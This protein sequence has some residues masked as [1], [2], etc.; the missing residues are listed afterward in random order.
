MARD[1]KINKEEMFKAYMEAAAAMDNN[2]DGVIKNSKAMKENTEEINK[3]VKARE[4]KTETVKK[5]KISMNDILSVIKEQNQGFDK[6][7]QY[8]EK[9]IKA[10]EEANK[11]V[12]EE[13]KIAKETTKQKMADYKALEKQLKNIQK[14][15]EKTVTVPRDSTEEQKGGVL[16]S[17]YFDEKGLVKNLD[18][19]K[20]VVDEI[21]GETI[22]TF[23]NNMIEVLK[24]VDNEVVSSTVDFKLLAEEIDKTDELVNKASGY[25]LDTKEGQKEFADLQ[26]EIVNTKNLITEMVDEFVALA[27]SDKFDETAIE[28]SLRNI[29][30]T[31][32]ELHDLNSE[33]IRIME[34]LDDVPISLDDIASELEKVGLEWKDFK[35]D[36]ASTD[37]FGNEVK[38]YK[39][40]YGNIL[41]TTKKIKEVTKDGVTSQIEQYTY[42]LSSNYKELY[43]ESDK[44]LKKINDL[45]RGISRMRESADTKKIRI[46]KQEIDEIDKSLERLKTQIT[47][48]NKENNSEKVAQLTKEYSKQKNELLKLADSYKE[49]NAQIRNQGGWMLNLKDSFVKAFRSFTTYMSVTNVFYQS[50]AAI[51][52]MINEVKELD[53]VLTEF[54]KVSD[55]AGSS[56]D[57]YV[58]KAGELGTEVAK[59]TSEMID[60]ATEFKKSGFGD[61]ESLELGKVA[62]MY[63]NIADE[64]LSAASAASFIIAQMKAFKIE[65][66]DAIHIVDALNEVSNN[67]AVSSAQLA[68]AIGKVS[69]TMEAGNTSY[70]QTLGLLTAVTEV[71]RNADKAANALKTIGQRIRGVGEDGEDASEYVASLQKEFDKLGISL[72]IV[73]NSAGEMESTYNILK[74]MAEKWEDLTETQR[75]SLGE[76]AAGKNRITELNALMSNWQTAVDATTTALNSNGSAVRENAKVLDSIEGHLQSLRSEW[77]KLAT[78]F[79]SSGLLKT[80]I[81]LGTAILRLAQSGIGKFVIRTSAMTAAAVALKRIIQL[82]TKEF[83]KSGIEGTTLYRVFIL[84]TQGTK[85]LQRNLAAT[86]QGYSQMTAAEKRARLESEK[87]R[88]AS[89]KINLGLTLLSTAISLVISLWQRHNEKIE[90]A[91]TKLVET[92]ETIYSNK[93]NIDGY[94][95]SIKEYKKT[96]D[97]ATSTTKDKE[98]AT[99]ALEDIENKLYETYGL[100]A[101]NIDLVNGS[102]ED[103]LD[104]VK[105]LNAA[106]ADKYF[107]SGTKS[108]TKARKEVANIAG[109]NGSFISTLPTS[110]IQKRNINQAKVVQGFLEENPNYNVDIDTLSGRP[111]VISRMD[112][113]ETLEYY[114]KLSEYLQR[115]KVALTQETLSEK[116]YQRI[117]ENVGQEIDDITNKYGKY[118]D[119]LN[120]AKSMI[121]ETTEGQKAFYDFVEVSKDSLTDEEIDSL[122]EKY[123]SLATKIDL[124]GLSYDEIREKFEQ[125]EEAEKKQNETLEETL[126]KFDEVTEKVKGASDIYNT[127]NSIMNEY[128]ENGYITAESL[129]TVLDNWET[130]GQYLDIVNGK[131]VLNTNKLKENYNAQLD[132]A[133]A[134]AY[135]NA[136]KALQNLENG[137]VAASESA[138]KKSVDASRQAYEDYTNE[139]L[140]NSA[141]KNVSDAD[142]KAVQTN[143]NKQLALIKK[144][145]KSLGKSSGGSS[146]SGSSGTAEWEKAL[147]N[148]NNQYKNSEITIE[149]YIIKL[150]ALAKK[151]KKNKTAVAE[152]SKAIKD[153]RLEKLEDDYKRGL[154]GVEEYIKGLKELQKEYK[155]STKEWNNFADKIKSALETLLKDRE[156]DY[157]SAQS[158]AVDLLEEEI[159]RLNKLKDETEKYYDDLIAAKKEANEETERELE[160]ARLQE[161]LE[162]AKNN[163]TKRVFVEG[164]GWQ[165]MRDEEAVSEAQKALDEFNREQETDALEKE[166]EAALK[167]MDEK[168]EAAEQY[169][170]SWLDITKAYEDEQN[171]LI[172]AEIMGA[173]AE[174]RILNQRLDV[175]E[176]F[177]T[178]YINILKDLDLMDNITAD[179]ISQNGITL[180]SG[181]S[182]AEGGVVD[183]TGYAKVHG[184]ANKPEIML[185]N[186]QA[187]SLYSMLKTPNF[188][189]TKLAGGGGTQIYN[190]DNLV[191]PN[192][193]NARQFINELKMITNI[194]KNQ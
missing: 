141:A 17:E 76:I 174:G 75:Q 148:L 88:I 38:K 96:L 175:L 173:D 190:F 146:K 100:Q 23:K 48:A 172:L 111:M 28:E 168:I 92:G 41:E 104:L 39:D 71:T 27:S 93:E 87:M 36:S 29:I 134:T 81:D 30:N 107:A 21:S 142:M 144:A 10:L 16:F 4:K 161:A 177:R 126:S 167:N 169:K 68:G 164:L 2:T 101:K 193:S 113:K 171:R 103:N 166:K 115:N 124:V 122:L 12:K 85:G 90:E 118:Y 59:T 69:A 1:L 181:G 137:K 44:V 70:E 35:V 150:E 40:A 60:A 18:A 187:A 51:R 52:S 62:N 108:I 147:N 99:K 83:R 154:I 43:N 53:E 54:K 3:N 55:L 5:E 64:S 155:E 149:Q 170:D 178:Q 11:K 14:Q 32:G 74:A 116:E 89:A 102:L 120:Q 61:Q 49:V 165:Y 112:Y 180:N 184:S 42:K 128:N 33:L 176:N 98:T 110:P 7:I 156:K 79:V 189:P 106:D 162:N 77:Q 159:D 194:S 152:L 114:E 117:L 25:K 129:K 91:R 143:L 34:N 82:L 56:L 179:A 84:Q 121:W 139:L 131:L 94:V 63:T 66:N 37:K 67:Y 26:S 127:L 135:D 158:A 57:S 19:I 80:I 125:V 192:V 105:K 151:Y 9:R 145:R 136:L 15:Q 78:S 46:I 13:A 45:D 119:T 160:L 153:A 157:K 50:A 31:T 86:V 163:R 97:D 182:Y 185:S 123:P 183:Y 95:E 138:V 188:A 132:E 22:Q 109:D 6:Q 24:V 191:L 58:K 72:K 8:Y 130:Y 140:A 133:E 47:I 186:S 73:K 65:A 20:N